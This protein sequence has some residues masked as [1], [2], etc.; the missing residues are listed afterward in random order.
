MTT[1][2]KT[3]LARTS[4][5]VLYSQNYAAGIRGHYHKSSDC[6]EYPKKSPLESRHPKKYL[7]N[8]P[9][10]KNP[11]I[12]NFKPKKILRSSPSL[13]IRSTSP[14]PPG[15]TGKKSRI[16]MAFPTNIHYRYSFVVCV[17]PPPRP[18]NRGCFVMSR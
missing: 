1:L 16:L 3:T 2:H 8:F 10:Q 11:G 7:P 5:V 6:F 13:E 15:S 9:T 18:S 12:E 14:P 4:L 17:C